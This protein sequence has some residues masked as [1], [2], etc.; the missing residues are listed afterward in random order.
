MSQNISI[1]LVEKTGTL[2]S[3][4]MKE[5]KEEDIYKKCGFKKS[6][7]FEKQTEWGIKLDGKKYVVALYGKS[8][9]K[10]N[11]ENKYDFPPPVDTVLFFGSCALVCSVKN[12]DETWSITSLSLEQWNKMYEKLFGGFEDLAATCAEDEEEE[13][14][15]ENI[16]ASKK[17]KQGY[18]KDGFVV[19][20][21]SSDKEEYESEQEDEDNDDEPSN[22]ADEIVD[23]ELEEIGSELS[24]EEYE[25]SSE[26]ETR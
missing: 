15:L 25:S 6:D 2:K 20:S 10:A 11:S 7:G 5:Y 1:V 22:D 8:D 14:E 19:D 9:G 12:L 18:L 23:L 16:P 4:T 26:D 17:T 21:D 24:E 3:H 13:D